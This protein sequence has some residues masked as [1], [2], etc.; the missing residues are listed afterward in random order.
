MSLRPRAGPHP[1]VW[2]L[3]FYGV[4][5]LVGSLLAASAGLPSLFSAPVEGRG[6]ASL[7]LA[8]ALVVAVV[9]GGR[10]LERYAWYARMA[11]LIG[12]VVPRLLGPGAGLAGVAL[13]AA[14]SSLGEEALFRGFLQPWA[15]RL[16]VERAH[17]DASVAVPLGVS[18]ATALFTSLH[19]PVHRDLL[20]WT[21]FAFAIGLCFGAL[22]VW[23]GSLAPPVLAHFLINFTNI[24]LLLRSKK[25]G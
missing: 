10:L 5:T 22:A 17:L 25:T 14:E 1:Q 15:I 12:E 9:G 2:N 13:L 3:A 7:G 6:L 4:M 23:S 18:L 16:L 20:P 19:P 11:A 8:L 21:L 24:V